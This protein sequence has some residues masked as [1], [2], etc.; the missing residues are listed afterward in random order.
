MDGDIGQGIDA[1]IGE[2]EG[3]A[4][5]FHQRLVLPDKARLGFRQDA[6]EVFLGQRTQFDADRQAALQF[7]QEVRRLGDMEGA[8]GD[9][10]DVVGLH[11]A[12]LRRH[13]RAFDQR[14]QVALHAF[15]RNAG[16]HAAVA[17]GDLVDLVEEDD[18]VILDRTD[19]LALDD[20]VV[21]QL[22]GLVADQIRVGCLDRGA[23]LLGAAAHRLA[24]HFR[25]G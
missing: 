11:R 2:L 3:E 9:E 20:F 1:V 5:G 8:G 18:A 16:T 22:V 25:Q 4:F 12:V 7:R 19:R 24:E 14:K 6:A 15:A 13:R 10:E 23:D 21:D 17:G